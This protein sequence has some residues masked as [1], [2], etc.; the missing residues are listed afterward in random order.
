M[1]AA[2]I[3][4]KAMKRILFT[5]IVTAI[6][7]SCS[8]PKIA[9]DQNT[10]EEMPVSG[11]QGF[12]FKQKLLF[13][14]FATTS[15]KRSWT[16]GSSYR[17]GISSGN[18]T[19]ANYENIISMEYEKKKQTLNF[20]LADG[21]NNNS[22]V[23][24]VTKFSSD[25]LIIGNNPNSLLNIGIDILRGIN[26]SNTFY[27]QIFI[28]E[29]AKPWQLLLD[30]ELM[31]AKPSSYTGLVALDKE[32][33]YTLVPVNKLLNKKGE[34]KKTLFG[35]VGLALKDRQNRTV[36]TVSLLN[37]GTVYLNSND[38]AERFLAANI[39]AALL[40]QEQIGG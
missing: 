19:D 39:C 28:N 24:C 11:R 23:R 8:T 14:E 17:T 40:L 27:A 29:Q 4:V 7:S 21:K 20:E 31:Q 13:G 36:A 25:E 38:L 35:S 10:S 26:S 6:F 18:P 1:Q 22:E 34:A 12:L 15:V 32:T 33:Y 9:V 3:F 2:A 16:K 5:V 37:K 30:N